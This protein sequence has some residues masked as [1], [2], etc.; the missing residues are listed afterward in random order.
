MGNTVTVVYEADGNAEKAFRR[1]SD[2]Y[3]SNYM[4][5]SVYGVIIDL[6][7]SVCYRTVS[8]C[9]ISEGAKRYFEEMKRGKN[10]RFFCAVRQRRYL[11]D[12]TELKKYRSSYARF[13]CEGGAIGALGLL[14]DIKK[15]GIEGLFAYYGTNDLSDCDKVYLCGYDENGENGVLP[16]PGTV[17]ALCERFD[18]KKAI[19]PKITLDKRSFFD[20]REGL[21]P[22]AENKGRA[23]ECAFG[24]GVCKD[25]G[26]VTSALSPSRFTDAALYGVIRL[27]RDGNINSISDAAL[28]MCAVAGLKE[29]GRLGAEEAFEMSENVFSVLRQ[30]LFSSELSKDESESAFLLTVL[31][32]AYSKF[33]SE[34]PE[35]IFLK[36]D[37]RETAD[38]LLRH[39]TG[40][41]IYGFFCSKEHSRRSEKEKLSFVAKTIIFGTSLDELNCFL[42]AR[43]GNMTYD[44]RAMA[45]IA[46]YDRQNEFRGYLNTLPELEYKMRYLRSLGSAGGY[47]DAL[48]T[49]N[50]ARRSRVDGML[51]AQSFYPLRMRF[52]DCGCDISLLPFAAYLERCRAYQ[53]RVGDKEN[54]LTL[55][56]DNAY[57]LVKLMLRASAIDPEATVCVVTRD[58]Y[59]HNALKKASSGRAR[60][61]TRSECSVKEIK[62]ISAVTRQITPYT[63]LSELCSEL[64]RLERS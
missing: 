27:Y 47:Y 11:S 55:F 2:V 18:G 36:N 16:Y 46:V 5:S 45:G 24:A 31:S 56:A 59:S 34:Y 14:I 10:G 15:N 42:R 62:N 13:A 64:E 30:L 28:M 39:S 12:L 4:E 43:A 54:T 63:V 26:I 22:L 58:R 32:G 50:G 40:E 9:K 57:P 21:Y 7:P 25:N 29:I 51:G 52:A 6:P 19:F 35:F 49:Y 48:N 53:S 44:I 20:P 23:T 8:D 17:N 60:L 38:I 1:L 33:S 3:N 61:I 41:S 37:V